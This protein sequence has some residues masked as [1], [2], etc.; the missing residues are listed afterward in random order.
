MEDITHGHMLAAMALVGMALGAVAAQSHFCTL[1]AL[2]DWLNFGD[3][4]RLRAWALACAV[5]MAGVAGLRAAGAID[6]ET[7]FPAYRSATF[8]PLRHLAGGGLFGIGMVLASGCLSKTLVRLGAGNLKSLLVL[9]AAAFSAYVMIWHEA[10]ARWFAPVLELAQ[11]NLA[12]GSGLDQWL[13]V[14]A[15]A[16][17]VPLA[18]S[19]GAWALADTPFRTSGGRV[20]AAAVIGVLV[21]LAW[22][23]TGGA[24]GRAWLESA[25]F[26]ELP[27]LRAAPQ[28]LTFV[29]PL[30]DG[31]HT[32]RA[33]LP[34]GAWSLGQALV[35][36]V[37][38]GAF[39]HA[40]V[41]GAWRLERF[42]HVAD[43]VRHLAGGGLM[44][45][46]G[47]MAMGC[48]L[49]QG[50]TGVSVLAL[51]SFL[52]LV[53]IVAGAV[54]TMRLEYRLL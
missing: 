37:V 34:I 46:G 4:G 42:R 41:A 52:S 12:G 35:V 1:G 29:A 43:A 32:L 33:G 11:Q 10:Y 14:P 26:S 13:G 15:L 20:A 9:A 23:L 8:N 39:A 6:I 28:S 27:P 5:A 54:F 44:G 19:L 16:C 51:G 18:L 24:P 47:V 53:G 2:S 40:R 17:A 30:A 31:V 25:N 7:S 49:G 3:S 50:L 22:W 38:L 48:S 21:V 36:G 45:V